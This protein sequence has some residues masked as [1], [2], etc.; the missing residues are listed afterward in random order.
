[1]LCTLSIFS[2]MMLSTTA[3]SYYIIFTHYCIVYVVILLLLF[4]SNR[5]IEMTF[6]K[7]WTYSALHLEV[8]YLQKN[9]DFHM[10]L[11]ISYKIFFSS[12][13]LIVS[14]FLDLT[15]QNCCGDWFDISPPFFFYHLGPDHLLNSKLLNF[16]AHYISRWSGP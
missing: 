9:N 5:F 15:I 14:N 8:D 2:N 11:P 1:M 13:L 10:L 3:M 7:K 4:T 6:Q 16:Y 12:I